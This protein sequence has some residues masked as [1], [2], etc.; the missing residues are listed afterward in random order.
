MV[1]DPHLTQPLLVALSVAALTGFGEL[2]HARRTRAVTAL[3][4]A[5][6]LA[7]AS[8][9]R[10]LQWIRP[11]ALALLAASLHTLWLTHPTAAPEKSPPRERNLIVLLDVSPSMLIRDAGDATTESRA[12]RASKLLTDL[13][14]R[15]PGD[16]VKISLAAFYTHT[17]P[18][19]Q[20]TTDR[21]V[22][23]HM[24]SELP[25]HILFQPGK[26]DL[27]KS[28]NELPKLFPNLPY[29]STSLLVLSD[30]DAVAKTG[31]NPLPNAF[32][33]V[34]FV[35]VGRTS[36]G[37]FIDDHNSRQDNASLASLA[38]RLRAS[39]QD[40]NQKPLALNVL[41][42]LTVPS[43]SKALSPNQLI[44]LAKIGTALASVLLALIPL[45]LSRFG[46]RRQ[47]KPSHTPWT[48][49]PNLQ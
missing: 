15:C 16:H 2:L 10:S 26:T 32:D 6:H 45:A 8:W 5:N 35:G 29:R 47:P 44:L 17:K 20:S 46:A 49:H 34:L 27:L 1:N 18:L 23:R 36:G 19:V 7:P 37:T 24:A 14:N 13:L 3:L 11:L 25:L 22:I 41:P 28:L 4:I 30:G 38:R 43:P 31:L 40:A 48:L 42:H 33:E 12:E 21:N 39:Y 9:T